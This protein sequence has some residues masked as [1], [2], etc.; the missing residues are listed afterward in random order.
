MFR[1][2][3]LGL[4]SYENARHFLGLSQPRLGELV[5]ADSQSLQGTS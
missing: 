5:G 4:A 3:Y 1:L 2:Y